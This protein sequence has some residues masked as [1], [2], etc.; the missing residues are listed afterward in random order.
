MEIEQIALWLKS[1]IP[2]VIILGVIGGIITLWL[3]KLFLY[4]RR[5]VS[6]SAKAY[7]KREQDK[8]FE[9]GVISGYLVLDKDGVLAITYACSKLSKL[10][11]LLCILI[12]SF[13]LFLYLTATYEGVFLSLGSFITVVVFFLSVRGTFEEYRDINSVYKHIY[14][15]IYENKIEP[16]LNAEQSNDTNDTDIS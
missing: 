11:L 3:S 10:L 7:E 1:T 8:G 16:I 2:G 14:N 9:S 5:L 13:S 4:L 15:H 12:I 6:K